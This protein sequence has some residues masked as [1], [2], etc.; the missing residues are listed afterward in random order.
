M[1]WTRGWEQAI[2]VCTQVHDHLQT[3]VKSVRAQGLIPENACFAPLSPL[4][5]DLPVLFGDSDSEAP[6][7]ESPGHGFSVSCTLFFFV[8]TRSNFAMRSQQ[9]LSVFTPSSNPVE[10]FSSS[11]PDRVGMWLEHFTVIDGMHPQPDE[12]LPTSWNDYMP[13]RIV[14]DHGKADIAFFGSTLFAPPSPALSFPESSCYSRHPTPLSAS[15]SAPGFGEDLTEEYADEPIMSPPRLIAPLPRRPSQT[16][17]TPLSSVSTPELIAESVPATPE[18]PDIP[19]AHAFPQSPPTQS[20]TPRPTPKSSSSTPTLSAS[21]EQADSGM[22]SPPAASSPLPSMSNL[23]VPFAD[24]DDFEPEP[25][26]D[27]DDD[28]DDDTYHPGAGSPRKKQGPASPRKRFAATSPRGEPQAIRVPKPRAKEALS[29]IASTSLT[30]PSFSSSTSLASSSAPLYHPPPK[31]ERR[32]KSDYPSRTA[33]SAAYDDHECK[34]C[35]HPPFTRV[36]D[37]D[38]HMHKSCWL[39]PEDLREAIVCDKCGT[40]VSRGDAYKRHQQKKCKGKR[41]IVKMKGCVR[42]I[43]GRVKKVKKA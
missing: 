14:R 39:R 8:A 21:Q 38:R 7:L 36:S 43:V 35:I 30:P 28:G 26:D 9:D 22:H 4:S 40:E 27:E 3:I 20:P 31:V 42:T 15:P 34:Y 1:V 13:P 11:S 23:R 2:K 25:S 18:S 17:T 24:D 29:P 16:P 37:A 33:E 41:G 5:F 10:E 6:L 12:S 19:L 32:P